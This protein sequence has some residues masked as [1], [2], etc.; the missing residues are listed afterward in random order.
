MKK[1]LQE[2]MQTAKI[3]SIVYPDTTYYVIDKPRKSAKV[4]SIGWLAMHKINCEGYYPVAS[5]KNGKQ[6]FK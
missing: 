2:A 3:Q 6:I 4:Y 1:S 5:F